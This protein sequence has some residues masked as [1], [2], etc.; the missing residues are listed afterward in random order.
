MHTYFKLLEVCYHKPRQSNCVK[1]S[2][3]CM[4][5]WQYTLVLGMEGAC[6]TNVARFWIKTESWLLGYLRVI[7]F[8][9]GRRHKRNVC[10]Q[11]GCY[12]ERKTLNLSDISL[13]V[14][15]SSYLRMVWQSSVENDF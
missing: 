3:E 12:W 7:I 15:V 5:Q 13:W 4:C 2:K 6:V 10:G 9:F 8:M 14:V 1:P 11:C